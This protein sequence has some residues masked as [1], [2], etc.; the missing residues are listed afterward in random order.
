MKPRGP[1]GAEISPG[2]PGILQGK[3]ALAAQEG[4]SLEVPA[5]PCQLLGR[6]PLSSP[7]LLFKMTAPSQ[8]RCHQGALLL[9]VIY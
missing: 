8:A 7:A 4:A 2:P 3:A 1:R 5:L 9:P 6:P